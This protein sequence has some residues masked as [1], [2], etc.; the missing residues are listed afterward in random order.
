[1]KLEKRKNMPNKTIIKAVSIVVEKLL[2]DKSKVILA[3]KYLSD[4]LIN[5]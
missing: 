4:K 2:D 3:E 1:M 5:V